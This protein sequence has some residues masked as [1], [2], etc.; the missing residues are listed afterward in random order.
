DAERKRG[1][2]GLRKPPLRV[3]KRLPQHP[4]EFSAV[5]AAVAGR[6][7]NVGGHDRNY[8]ARLRH[9]APS[10]WCNG[11]LHPFTGA[12]YGATRSRLSSASALEIRDVLERL[13]TDVV[14]EVKA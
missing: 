13:A 7:D 5:L 10:T 1:M 9:S 2:D 12:Q 14:S 3:G 4:V 6:V 8:P 11:A